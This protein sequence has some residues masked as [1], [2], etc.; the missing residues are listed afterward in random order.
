MKIEIRTGAQIALLTFCLSSCASI[1]EDLIRSPQVSLR[2]VQVVG[3]GFN[4][5]TFLLSF[6]V[7]NSNPFPLPVRNFDYDVRLDG[8]RFASGETASQF[9]IPADGNA[10]FA[11]SVDLN[12]LQTAP[13]LLTIVQDGARREIRYDLTG[14]FG[15]DLPL[16][17][18][19]TYRDNGVLRV[20]AGSY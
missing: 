5:Q 4:A 12:L 13:Q 6:D 11:I 19:L 9:T 3:L 17:P 7:A 16:T 1:T 2:N 10:S 15:V 18:V 8:Q 14:R 20:N